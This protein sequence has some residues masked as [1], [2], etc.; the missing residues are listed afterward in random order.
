MATAGAQGHSLANLRPGPK[1]P[2][3]RVLPEELDEILTLARSEEY[4]DLSTAS[5]R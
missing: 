1:D 4:V 5:W 2:L 3:H